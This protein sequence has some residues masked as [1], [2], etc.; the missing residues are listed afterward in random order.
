MGGGGAEIGVDTALQEF[1]CM[2]ILLGVC[3]CV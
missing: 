3:V 1:G 2:G